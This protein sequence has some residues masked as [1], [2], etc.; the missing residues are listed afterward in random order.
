MPDGP[1]PPT[2]GS[3]VI[4]SLGESKSVSYFGFSNPLDVSYGAIMLK[5]CYAKA[6]QHSP[7]H[8]S[9]IAET[10]MSA[11]PRNNQ[12]NPLGTGQKK[13]PA[14]SLTS[15]MLWM[16]FLILLFYISFELFLRKKEVSGD[17][18]VSEL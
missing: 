16:M 4:M 1:P 3:P 12:H 14:E 8:S 15:K 2:P 13:T 9:S 6:P 7:A 10:N 5:L 18:Y 11:V 17:N